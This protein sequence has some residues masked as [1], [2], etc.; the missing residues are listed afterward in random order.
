M[1]VIAV[2]SL[3]IG[4]SRTAAPETPEDHIN[5]VA[6]T[7]KCP[8]CQGESVADSNA[9]TSQEI[10]RDIADR[11]NR[12]ETD[13]QIRGFYAASYGQSI[14]LTPSG[15][16]VTALVWVLPVVVLVGAV[17]GLGVAFRRWRARGELHATADDRELVARALEAREPKGDV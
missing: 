12:G 5:A 3:M 4:A 2:A 1:A 17:A 8:T 10:R 9:P 14:L 15:S 16:G 11:L 6:K 7:I 13:D